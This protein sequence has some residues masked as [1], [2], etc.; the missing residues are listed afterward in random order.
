[1]IQDASSGQEIGAFRRLNERFPE[2]WM[3]ALSIF[4]WI[5]LALGEREHAHSAPPG[6]NLWRWM[7]MVIAMMLPLQ[8]QGVRLTAERSLWTRRHRAI[9]GFLIGYLS[10]W[11]LPGVVVS[12]VILS[13]IGSGT[14][15]WTKGA[16]IGFMVEAAWLLSP[17]KRLAMHICNKTLPLSPYGWRANRDCISYGSIVGYGCT[18]NCWPLMMG[19]WLSGHSIVVMLFGYGLGWVDR[20]A[21]PNERVHALVAAALS[22]GFG[23]LSLV[24]R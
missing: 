5:A 21:M 3:L 17:G 1:M 4:A 23:A 13:P 6:M 20:H 15:N 7:L 9:L 12:Y 11:I 18:L 8:I 16:A 24:N 14:L 2:Y 10:V 22:A 19:C